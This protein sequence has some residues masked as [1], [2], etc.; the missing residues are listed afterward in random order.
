MAGA[1]DHSAAPPNAHGKSASSARASR[2]AGE[3]HWAG[4]VISIAFNIA[5][6]AIAVQLRLAASAVGMCLCGS[7]QQNY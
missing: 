1:L 2:Q 3:P 5:A 7:T 6:R 4:R